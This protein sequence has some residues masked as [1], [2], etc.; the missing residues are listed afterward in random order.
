[1]IRRAIRSRITKFAFGFFVGLIL[2]WGAGQF[3]R[4]DTGIDLLFFLG[5]CGAF[6]GAIGAFTSED[7]F[8]KFLSWFF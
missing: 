4:F 6:F 1:M 8:V 3:T 7:G 5:G 2:G